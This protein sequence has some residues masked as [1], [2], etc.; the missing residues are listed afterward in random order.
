MAIKKRK[1]LKGVIIRFEVLDIEECQ[2]QIAK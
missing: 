2:C 1:I